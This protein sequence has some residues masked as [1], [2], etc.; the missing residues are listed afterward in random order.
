MVKQ[1]L[2]CWRRLTKIYEAPDNAKIVLLSKIAGF[3]KDPL[4][5]GRSCKESYGSNALTGQAN[6]THECKLISELTQKDFPAQLS[7]AV[8]CTSQ[9]PENIVKA[10]IKKKSRTFVGSL[11]EQSQTSSNSTT[12]TPLMPPNCW[13][14]E[15]RRH[16]VVI[17]YVSVVKEHICG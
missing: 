8:A 15:W 12:L 14:R 7:T 11:W 4:R 13:R 10:V 9:L 17:L 5:T 16:N 2:A 1:V 3:S 6:C